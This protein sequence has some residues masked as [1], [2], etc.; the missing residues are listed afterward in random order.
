MRTEF[1]E[2][3]ALLGVIGI[4]S[5]FAMT[6]YCINACRKF[7]KQLKIMEKGIKAQMRSQLIKDY[8]VY[9]EEGHLSDVELKEWQNQ[10][11]AYTELQGPNGV[12]EDRYNKL[13]ALPIG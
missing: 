1:M 4:P 12:L 5:I 11:E 7:S 3:M 6:C 10:Y 8:G 13:L 9:T 2:V